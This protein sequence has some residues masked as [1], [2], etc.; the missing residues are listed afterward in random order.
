M[1]FTSC[2]I[3]TQTLITV[4]RH[5]LVLHCCKL[6]MRLSCALDHLL[7]YLRSC[8]ARDVFDV[9]K[10]VCRVVSGLVLVI[11]SMCDRQLGN[12]KCQA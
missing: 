7:T 4:V 11:S 3:V 9:V 6:S 12:N 5:F 2:A 1:R 8:R 10:R